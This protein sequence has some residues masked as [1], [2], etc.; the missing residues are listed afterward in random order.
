LPAKAVCQARHS[1]QTDCVRGQA[2]SY[3]G[4]LQ[5]TPSSAFTQ[6][7]EAGLPAKA[8]CQARHSSQADCVRGQ[9]RSYRGFWQR[10]QLSALRQSVGAG[11]LAKAVCQARH[12]SQ[13]DCVQLAC[14]SGV[15]GEASVTG[16]LR[17]RASALL[18]GILATHTIVGVHAIRRS[19]LACESGVSG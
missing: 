8:V 3:N 2:R 13:A 7:V 11:L 14:E 4:S 5:R 17:S 18:Q 12:S 6:S 16:R 9:A 19:R 10:T 15:S 1:S